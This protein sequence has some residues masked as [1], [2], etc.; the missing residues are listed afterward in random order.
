MIKNAEIFPFLFVSN[1]FCYF[2][3]RLAQDWGISKEEA[4]LVL[5]AWYADRPEVLEWQRQTQAMAKSQGCV[6]T[7][8]GR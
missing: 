3:G 6:R 1:V 4:E 8:L 7:L 2:M 5:K